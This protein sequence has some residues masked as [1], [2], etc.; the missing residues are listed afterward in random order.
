M[1]CDSI[2][3]KLEVYLVATVAVV[4]VSGLAFALS[5]PF[6][7]ENY[8]IATTPNAS[9]KAS[10]APSHEPVPAVLDPA[11]RSLDGVSYHG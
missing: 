3:K 11:L 7:P 1:K 8:G 5:S 9:A 6:S 2:L 10:A 4:L